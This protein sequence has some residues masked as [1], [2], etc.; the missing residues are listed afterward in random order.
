MAKSPEEALRTTLARVAPGTHLRD[1]LE[2]ILRG[3][4]GALIVL[5][6]GPHRGEHLLRRLRH[7]H[8]VLAPP[9]CANWPRWTARSC[10]DRDASNI[11]KAGVQLVPDHTIPTAG[12]G[13]PPPHGRARGH[14]DRLPGDLRVPV[15]ADHRHLRAGPSGTSW[16]APSPCWPAPT[17]RW[18]TL[19]RYRARLDQ[20]TS[21]LSALE[22]EAMVTVR[23]VASCCSARRW[24]AGS[25]RRSPSTCW[26]SAST[27]A[28]WRCSW[29]S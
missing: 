13:H 17:R 4:T 3:R 21:T 5:G 22:I 9:G 23:D 16:K 14:P 27:G 25:P 24:S 20:V 10:C 18:Q 12:D 19:E 26:S 7:Q 11:L 2:R 8:R 28:C 15:D 6:H 29:R 1:G